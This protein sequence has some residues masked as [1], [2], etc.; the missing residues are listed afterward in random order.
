HSESS[1][2]LLLLLDLIGRIGTK[3]T[4]RLSRL[5]R[6]NL[7]LA[8]TFRNAQTAPQTDWCPSRRQPHIIFLT[9]YFHQWYCLSHNLDSPFLPLFRAFLLGP[10]ST[11][12]SGLHRVIIK[13]SSK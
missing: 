7:C 6:S 3:R 12:Q 4:K 10:A 13:P 9:F 11:S 5:R 1:Y 8:C 2:D